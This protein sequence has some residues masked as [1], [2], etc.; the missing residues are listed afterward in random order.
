MKLTRYLGDLAFGI[1]QLSKNNRFVTLLV[2]FQ[3][4]FQ[5][6]Q[7]IVTAI[8]PSQV[9]EQ[10]E[11]QASIEQFLLSVGITLLVLI[12]A[13][14]LSSSL[15][16][17]V[18]DEISSLSS[19]EYSALM[20]ETQMQ[21]DYAQMINPQYKIVERKALSATEDN[22]THAMTLFE[23]LSAWISSFL[24]VIVFST[25]IG[26]VNFLL[27]LVIL[28]CSII[29]WGL[30]KKARTYE[31]SSK[32]VRTYHN[33]KLNYFRDLMRN[34]KYA[35][36][37]RTFSLNDWLHNVANATIEEAERCDKKIKSKY[38][39]AQYFEIFSVFMR[40]IVVYGYLIIYL[41]ID[42]SVTASTFVLMIASVNVLA[43]K[44]Y[45]ILNT[46][47]NLALAFDGL[48]D[49]REYLTA[50]NQDLPRSMSIS[51]VETIKFVNVSY[52]YPGT[53]KKAL[54][55]V[56]FTINAGQTLAIVGFNGAGK[57]T[58]INLIC[59]LIRP[60]SGQIF[61]N[62]IDT[63]TLSKQCMYDLV[64]PLFQEFYYLTASIRTN[65]TH[66]TET[67]ED[68]YL[69]ECLQLSGLDKV[70]QK[71][72]QKEDTKLVSQ[73]LPDAVEL[74]GGEK[75]KL[76]LARALYKNAQIIVLDEPTAAL[77][78]MSEHQLYTKF[79]SLIKGRCAIFISHRLASTQFC[80]Q[81]IFLKDGEVVETGTHQQLLMQNGEYRKVFE[82][83]RSYYQESP[84][85][86]N[87][88]D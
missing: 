22:H 63:A 44:V 64:A 56:S 45:N 18:N 8:L 48:H 58:I 26:Q 29:D 78:P 43:E 79:S 12:I 6:I 28:F 37:I 77:D 52:T 76:A 23:I 25:I 82:I 15:N 42:K 47:N 20:Q 69:Q 62:D 31:Y 55:S 4:M 83:Q 59:G 49:I 39:H 66:S 1:K 86:D 3:I 61:I 19:F 74:S 46:T 71:F 81:I 36:E 17:Y 70:V 32:S 84:N 9:V 41:L 67:Y 51:I 30:L 73:F 57:S 72:P 38:L 33:R 75:Q 65:I 21:Y 53:S 7:S 14:T 80:D 35:K 54:N 85:K 50:N 16:Y 40:D 2:V 68:T 34:V 27:V 10:I 13:N 88:E 5:V 11:M 24:S 87:E 60:S